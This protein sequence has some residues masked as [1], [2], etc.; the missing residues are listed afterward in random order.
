MKL[1]TPSIQER[2]KR[3]YSSGPYAGI[4]ALFLMIIDIFVYIF[5]SWWSPAKDIDK[6]VN[7]PHFE[8]VE[9]KEKFGDHSFNILEKNQKK[10]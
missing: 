4:L 6:A 3:Y 2:V 5:I 7:F 1:N 9:N 10:K 8:Y